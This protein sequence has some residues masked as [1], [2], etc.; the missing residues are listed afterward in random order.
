MI[1]LKKVPLFCLE[2]CCSQHGL[3][4]RLQANGHFSVSLLNAHHANELARFVSCIFVFQPPSY[5]QS[6]V[7]QVQCTNEL[8]GTVILHEVRIVVRDRNDNT[9]RFQQPRYYVAINEVSFYLAGPLLFF[10]GS[11]N[12]FSWVTFLQFLE[13]IDVTG[14][15]IIR[16]LLKWVALAKTEHLPAVIGNSI[17]GLCQCDGLPTTGLFCGKWTAVVGFGAEAFSC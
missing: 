8:V 16:S 2:I 4:N 9:P 10:F 14:V 13:N 11:C 15:H 6:I 17:S 12:D 3:H 1:K 5:I 7:V